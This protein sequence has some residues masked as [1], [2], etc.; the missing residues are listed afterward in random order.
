MPRQVANSRWSHA[1]DLNTETQT[2]EMVPSMGCKRLKNEDL[3]G[4][5]VIDRLFDN[6]GNWVLKTRESLVHSGAG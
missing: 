5:Q 1:R 4:K 2:S 6:L 3:V